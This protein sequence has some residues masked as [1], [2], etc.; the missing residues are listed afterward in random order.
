MAATPLNDEWIRALEGF[1]HS[2]LRSAAWGDHLTKAFAIDGLVLAIA[3]HP[4]LWKESLLALTGALKAAQGTRANQF[5]A[6]CAIDAVVKAADTPAQLRSDLVAQVPDLM[7]SHMPLLLSGSGDDEQANELRLLYNAM[8]RSW[9]A[10]TAFPPVVIQRCELHIREALRKQRAAIEE[11]GGTGLAEARSKQSTL[12]A[13]IKKFRDAQA[14]L[15][16]D[17][18]I[19]IETGPQMVAKFVAALYET[20]RTLNCCARCGAYFATAEAKVAHVQLHSVVETK[21]RGSLVRLRGP[22]APDF[23]QH[24]VNHSSGKFVENFKPLA[25]AHAIGGKV[26]T[27]QLSSSTD[28]LQAKRKRGEHSTVVVSDPE[29]AYSCVQCLQPL[30]PQLVRSEWVLTDVV[31]R[32]VLVEGTQQQVYVHTG[33]M[34]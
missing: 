34:Q 4:A 6:W 31:E 5:I 7:A 3:D 17:K 22:L 18:K 23:I 20:R 32:S 14:K 2:R 21:E 27:L 24:S 12:A 33:C 25:D 16:V 19:A 13:T 29:R 8:V 30:R 15:A 26:V 28:E 10:S 11:E 1:I 9:A